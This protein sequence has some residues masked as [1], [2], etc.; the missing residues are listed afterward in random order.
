MVSCFQNDREYCQIC[1]KKIRKTV[2]T[3]LDCSKCS[4]IFSEISKRNSK[5]NIARYINN[6]KFSNIVN[7]QY[8]CK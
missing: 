8:N 3:S 2:T 1:E 5:V 7:K 6:K 4:K